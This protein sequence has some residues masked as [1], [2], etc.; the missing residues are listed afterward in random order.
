M[1]V[2]NPKPPAP[3]PPA[4][5]A[6]LPIVRQALPGAAGRVALRLQPQGRL[7][8]PPARR[9]L[10]RAILQDAAEVGGGAVFDTTSG[11]MLLRR[12]AGLGRHHPGRRA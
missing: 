10:A 8:G 6:L 9:R 2:T 1:I 7:A 4:P 11:E 3:K 12:A 5:P